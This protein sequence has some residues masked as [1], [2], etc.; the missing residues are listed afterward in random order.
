MK[1]KSQS[2]YIVGKDEVVTV[3]IIAIGTANTASFVVDTACTQIS[4]DPIIYE[5]TVTKGPG[6]THF[7]E[8][9]GAFHGPPPTNLQSDPR[10]ESFFT[11]SLGGGRFRGPVIRRSDPD[12]MA[13][14]TFERP[15]PPPSAE[16]G[17]EGT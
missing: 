9:R 16:D 13:D 7:G 12:Q 6:E 8:L 5:F 10:F 15:A 17:T 2:R 3:E 1:Q 4:V 11:G 14:V